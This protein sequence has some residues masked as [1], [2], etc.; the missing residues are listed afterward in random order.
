MNI[1][2]I[3]VLGAGTMGPGIA[4][5]Y[6]MGGYKVSLYN[7]LDTAM[8]DRAKQT[9][10]AGLDFFVEQDKIT[11]AESQAMLANISY[12]I[13]LDEALAGAD[14]IQETIVENA[15]IKK[16]LF[17]QLDAKLPE[18]VIIVSNTSALNPFELMPERR[19]A[20]FAAAHWFAPPHI[21]PLVEV[22]KG[23]RT[24]E[25][26]MNLVSEVLEKSGKTPVRL[27]KFVPGYIINRLQILLNTEVF[28]LLDNEIC[29]PE[30]LDMAVKASLMPRGLLLG[31][32]QR[33]DFTG[34]DISARNIIN[35]SYQM[36]DTSERP[37]ALFD[38]VDKG[39]LGVKTGKGFFDYEGR[40]PVEVSKRRDELLFKI[41][42]L[43]KD[44]V[45]E[46]I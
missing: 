31:L 26:T 9:V 22:C 2:K 3:A 19:L 45:K 46:K 39:E 44:V 6:A 40:S 32:V 15:E 27:E 8:L 28:Y 38:H 16:G 37:K 35:G 21:L 41:F 23:E 17:E 11:R 1:N 25:Q 13:D 24:S 7:Y 5:S 29:S 43:T 34:L 18:G 36:P 12:T 33:Y 20:N 42:D 30:Q 14:Y 10:E 4:L